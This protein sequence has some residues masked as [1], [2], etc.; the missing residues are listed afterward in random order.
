[1][2]TKIFLPCLFLI[3][4]IS[5]Q[6]ATLQFT[7]IPVSEEANMWWARVPADLTGNG[8]TDLALQDNNAYG[9]WLGYIEAKDRHTW[10]VQVIAETAPNGN[11]FAAGD[12]DAAD[13][14]GDGDMDIL[15]LAHP[16]EWDSGAAPTVIYWYSNPEWEP[17]L[18]GEAPAFVK[19]I[20]L[21]D[22]NNDGKPDVVTATFEENNLKVYRQDSPG[23]WTA[24][25]DTTLTNLHE[26]M[27]VGDIDG[28]GD[29]DI[30]PNGYWIQNPGGDMT[31]NWVIRSIND[32]WHNQEGDWSR[33]ASKVFCQ[34]INK[35]GKDEIFISHSERSGYPVAYYQSD[36]PV[37]GNWTE[38]ILKEDFPAAH[39]LQVYD[40]DL[41]GDFDVLSGI[42]KHRAMGIGVEDAF[43]VIIFINEGNDTW[44]EMLIS[45]GGIYNAQCADIEGDG[46]IDIFRLPTHDDTHFEILGNLIK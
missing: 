42:N 19:D 32:K 4:L 8:F 5:C 18:I 17:T 39:S 15:G 2:N 7:D 21:K 41:D 30:A 43:P 11:T 12:L 37:S 25:L 6:Q 46:D 38:H 36:D 33:N 16:G 29:I 45:E 34:D 23:Q 3:A 9:G 44:T 40:F 1:M 35:D 24:I 31:G 27:D 14:D 10:E 28:D 26:G 20:N 22:L 13:I